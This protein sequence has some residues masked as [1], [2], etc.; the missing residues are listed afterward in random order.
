LWHLQIEFEL[1]HANLR[2]MYRMYKSEVLQRKQLTSSLK[3]VKY[4]TQYLSIYFISFAKNIIVTNFEHLHTITRYR[5][6][7]KQN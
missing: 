7:E 3:P 6:E 4:L 5:F 2:G 1:I